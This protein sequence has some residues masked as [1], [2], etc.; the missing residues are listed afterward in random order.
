MSELLTRY[1]FTDRERQWTLRAWA[2]FAVAHL[3]L[4]GEVVPTAVPCYTEERGFFHRPA[5]HSQIHH[6]VP[7]YFSR[8]AR[9]EDPNYASNAAPVSRLNHIGFGAADEDFVIHRD[10]RWAQS[11]WSKYKQGLIT[12]P[13]EE[14]QRV[15]RAKSARGESYH[16]PSYDSYLVYMSRTVASEYQKAHSKD[17]WPGKNKRI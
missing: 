4:D 13:Y 14:I 1:G 17:L 6:I 8:I 7:Q 9:R 16:D 10:V 12:N 5:I 3:G 2:W 15:A 11:Q